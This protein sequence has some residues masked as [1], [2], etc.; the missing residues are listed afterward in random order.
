[1]TY[2]I[3][4][5]EPLAAE[6]LQQAIKSL[7]P[8]WV[9]LAPVESVRAAAEALREHKPDLLFL[10]IHLSDG[11]SFQLFDQVEVVCPIIFTTAFDQYALRAFKL[12]SIDYLLKPI[13]EGELKRALDKRD[14]W[15][16]P[17]DGQLDWNKVERDLKPEYRDRFLVS[18]GERVKS[19]PAEEISFFFAQG[20]H[21]FITDKQGREY[22]IDQP[23]TQLI[24]QLD[25]KQFFQINRKF[26]ICFRC[27]EE[28]IPYS[29][30]RLKL[31]TAPPT[32][33][34]AVVSVDKSAR[35]KAWLDG[36]S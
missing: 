23:L 6:K 7:R 16:Q 19:L 4:E 11:L 15:T 25:P 36:R 17:S 24:E 3:V 5:D 26:I 27:I 1:M 22:L 31:V 32:P 13:G 34:D 8:D 35:F 9:A 2:L 10:D 21:S 28:M 30:G 12:N 20:K 29:K 14:R 33:E 18:T